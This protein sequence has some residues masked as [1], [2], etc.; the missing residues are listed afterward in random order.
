MVDEVGHPRNGVEES[1]EG[2]AP[3][4]RAELVAPHRG[5]GVTK[6]FTRLRQR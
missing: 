5:R 3:A 6:I 2:A 4:L 1:R